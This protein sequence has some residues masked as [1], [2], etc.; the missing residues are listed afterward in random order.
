M[1][2]SIWEENRAGTA[3]GLACQSSLFAKQLAIEVQLA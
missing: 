2:S 1:Y 3:G